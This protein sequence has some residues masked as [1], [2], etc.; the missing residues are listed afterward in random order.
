MNADQWHYVVGGSSKGPLSTQDIE[1]LIAR[2]EIGQQTLVWNETLPAW[3]PAAAHFEMSQTAAA[4]AIPS[5]DGIGADGLYVGAPSRGFREALKVCLRKY[6]TFSGRA[7]RSEYWYFILWQLLLGFAATFL[8][9]ILFGSLGDVSPLN[10]I[11]SLAFILPTFAV[12]WRRLHD[13]NRSGWWIGGF[14][15][16][17]FAAGLLG[18]GL[19]VDSSQFEGSNVMMVAGI[20]LIFAIYAIVMLVFFCARGTLGPNRF[21]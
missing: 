15:I 18:A 10:S 17:A 16:G 21:G 7:S 6:V 5:G 20:G 4:P 9:V 19:V 12:S 14:Y 2:G 13:V 1:A 3:E 11:L 8:D